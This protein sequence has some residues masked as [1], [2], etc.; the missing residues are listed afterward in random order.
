M[1]SY[2]TIL[3]GPESRLMVENSLFIAWG[4]EVGTAQEL[5][6]LKEEARARYPDATHHCLGGILG[7]QMLESPRVP[8]GFQSAMSC[9]AM[10]CSIVLW[11]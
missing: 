6:Q 2:R 1:T 5:R 4:R 11:W 10:A 7:E 3:E 8:Q 9:G